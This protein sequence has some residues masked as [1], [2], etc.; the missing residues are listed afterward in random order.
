M[1]METGHFTPNSLQIFLR[2]ILRAN[3]LTNAEET[4]AEARHEL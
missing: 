3:R 2:P 1:P 4:R